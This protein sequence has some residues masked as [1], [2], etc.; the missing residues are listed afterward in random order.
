VVRG[1]YAVLGHS[2]LSFDSFGYPVCRIMPRT[3]PAAGVR[4][5]EERRADGS[6]P[7]RTTAFLP[8][9]AAGTALVAAAL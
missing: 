3:L 5:L 4:N 7:A 9:M 8:K 1:R 6:L 2:M